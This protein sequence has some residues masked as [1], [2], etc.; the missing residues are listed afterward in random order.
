[1]TEE[2]SEMMVLMDPDLKSDTELTVMFKR[3]SESACSKLTAMDE[4]IVIHQQI[5][6]YLSV[7]TQLICVTC[8]FPFISCLFAVLL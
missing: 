6:D 8:L 3:S 7:Q 5:V 4:H 2:D 1:M